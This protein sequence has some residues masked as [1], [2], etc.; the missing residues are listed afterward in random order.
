MAAQD[1]GWRNFYAMLVHVLSLMVA[2]SE[3]ECD[4]VFWKIA[5]HV[6]DLAMHFI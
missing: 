1:F 4:L 6:Q 2:N 3:L 5:D